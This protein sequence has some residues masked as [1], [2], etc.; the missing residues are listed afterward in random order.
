M[1]H[2]LT[3]TESLFTYSF[4]LC[5][6]NQMVVRRLTSVTAVTLGSSWIAMLSMML[7]NTMVRVARKTMMW[8]R[9]MRP[10]MTR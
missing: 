2:S 8:R 5:T 6:E 9:P 3:T 7:S 1:S 10:T 4:I